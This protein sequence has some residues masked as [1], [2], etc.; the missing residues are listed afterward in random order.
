[1]KRLRAVGG[2]PLA[3][4]VDYDCPVQIVH[5]RCRSCRALCE[6]NNG[7]SCDVHLY[8]ARQPTRCYQ[9]LWDAGF[10]S[11]R[12]HGCGG[13][14]YCRRCSCGTGPAQLCASGHGCSGPTAGFRSSTPSAPGGLWNTAHPIG[15]G[16]SCPGRWDYRGAQRFGRWRRSGHWDQPCLILVLVLQR[17][18]ASA[19]IFVWGASR[20][21]K[22]FPAC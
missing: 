20:A 9:R 10:G 18:A 5:R 11:S 15:P 7:L 8:P 16:W 13:R 17:M 1:M 4:G 22:S 6:P 3:R 21:A 12:L 19:A 2:H 14:R